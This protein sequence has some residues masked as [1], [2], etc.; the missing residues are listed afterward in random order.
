[1]AVNHS[2]ALE[3]ITMDE[4]GHLLVPD[5][6][7]ADLI[8]AYGD[9]IDVLAELNKAEV[10]VAAKIARRKGDHTRLL[11]SWLLR[12]VADASPALVRGVRPVLTVIH[13]GAE[14]TG[15]SRAVLG[16]VRV[17][18]AGGSRRDG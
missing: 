7:M 16:L 11:Q 6:V 13:G 14:L 3:R 9:R 2:R 12:A 5:A 15:R 1:M 4:A 17:A 10:W 8:D 18:T